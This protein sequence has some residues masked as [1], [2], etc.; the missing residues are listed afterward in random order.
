MTY[1]VGDKTKAVCYFCDKVVT[2]TYSIQDVPFKQQLIKDILA[3]VCEG[4]NQVI[5]IPQQ[6]VKDIKV[7]L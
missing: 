2:V 1:K 6:S 3:G 7:Q 4:C 5:T